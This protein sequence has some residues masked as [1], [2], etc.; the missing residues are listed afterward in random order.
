MENIVQ[1]IVH[2]SND[3]LFSSISLNFSYGLF[4][5]FLGAIINNFSKIISNKLSIVDKS[6]Q[7]LIH[8]LV[9]SIILGFINKYADQ[10][11]SWS[12]LHTVHG[13]FFIGFFFSTQYNI[14]NNM[15]SIYDVY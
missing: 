10:R 14:F 9:C 6:I 2:N 4:G 12:W 7:I 5:I 13:L 1:N 11:F 8:L 15:Q 3:S